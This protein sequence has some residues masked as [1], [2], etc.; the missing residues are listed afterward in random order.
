M[1]RH[2]RLFAIA[3]WCAA[4]IS[5]F[6][7]GVPYST[8]WENPPFTAGSSA[9]GIDSWAAGSGSGSSQTVS[10]DVAHSGTQS[11][12]WDNSGT[13]SSFYSIRRDYRDITSAEKL[14]VSTRVWIS[15]ATQENRLYGIYL[16]GSATGTLGS[17]ILGITIG[18]DGK[19]RAGTT[20]S[21]T[22][23][24]STWLAQAAPGTYAD[25]WLRMELTLDRGNDTATVKIEGF[26]DGS[27][28]SATFSQSTGPRNVNIGTDYVTTTNR[29]GVGY[30][31]DLEIRVEAAAPFDG[32]DET[33][34]GG[35][36]AGD[37]IETAQSTAGNPIN[38]IRGTIGAANDVDIY[39]ITI[40]DPSTFSAT[41]IGGTS[42]DTAL[43]L[44]DADGK[45]VLHNEDD[46]DATS[47]T[48]S[49]I[50]NRNFVITQPGTYY[51]A[52]S[53]FGRRAA[54]CD[55]GLIW[56]ATP[57]RSI[58]TPDGPEATSRHG[59]WSGATSTTGGY[60][61][62][63]TGVAG[64]TTGNPA[65]CPPPAPWDEQYYGG[66]D[67]GDLPATAQ[68]VTLPDRQACQDTVTR[69]RGNHEVD[70]VDMY[71]ICITDPAQ[72]VAST[73]G[74]ASWDTQLWLFRCDGTGVVFNDD[75]TGTQSLIDNSTGCITEAGTYLLAISRYNRDAVDAGGNLLWNNSPFTGVRCADGPGAANPIAGWTGATAA[76]GTCA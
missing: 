74:G 68:L 1:M 10:T 37:T 22:Y 25:R 57:Y 67:A 71:V 38:T 27:V 24:S 9:V 44:F 75:S 31:D 5:A 19:V 34:N 50:D 58:R 45:G 29:A 60:R 7:Q 35:G 36:D 26:S 48:Q 55:G 13:F 30:F 21:A 69:I 15:S 2:A 12:Q 33:A 65:D 23:S 8:S 18:G 70:D 56:N 49:R 6:A 16:T 4:S 43:W 11:L 14:V 73:V 76:G 66:G 59:G 32:W 62:F 42:L 41:T 20:W 51:L 52:V 63:L 3:L 39:A 47:G 53:L 28:I 72:F 40:T 46:P 61:I 64:G 17:T 54:G